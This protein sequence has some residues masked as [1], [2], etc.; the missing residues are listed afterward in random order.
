MILFFLLPPHFSISKE[1][2]ISLNLVAFRQKSSKLILQNRSHA[3]IDHKKK[4]GEVK[5]TFFSNNINNTGGNRNN[6]SVQRMIN[7]LQ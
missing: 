3:A 6:D 7:D 1:I 4:I 5:L 2:N